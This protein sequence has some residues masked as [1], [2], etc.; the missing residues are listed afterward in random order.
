MT[1]CDYPFP[2]VDCGCDACLVGFTFIEDLF[3]FPPTQDLIEDALHYICYLFP[4]GD[5]REECKGFIEQE[6][7]AIMDWVAKKFPPQFICTAVNACDFPVDPIEDGL[8][9]FCEGAFQ[10]MYDIFQYDNEYGEEFIKT[11]LDYICFVFPA[12]ESRDT[13]SRFIDQEYEKLVD[14]IEFEFPP[15]SIC[16]LAGACE[17]NITPEYKTECEFCYIFYQ[18]ALDLIEFDVTVEAV[19]DLLKYIC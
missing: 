2:P 14:F 7:E 3:E 4:K 18:F 11:V 5:L 9:I 19:E 15:E 17:S 12:G 13:C 10:F 16:I 8:C 6:F 1:A